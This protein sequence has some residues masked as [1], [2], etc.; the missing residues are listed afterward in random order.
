MLPLVKKLSDHYK[1][2]MQPQ[3]GPPIEAYLRSDWT[4]QADS[5]YASMVEGADAPGALDTLVQV[6]SSQVGMSTSLQS[7]MAT[8]Q[9]WTGSSPIRFSFELLFVAMEDARK[10]VLEPTARLIT[11]CYPPDTRLGLFI[12]PDNKIVLTVGSFLKVPNVL[13][14]TAVPTY[15]KE[16]TPEGIPLGATVQVELSTYRTPVGNEIKSFFG[17]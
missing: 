9:K 6:A 12:P 17:I 15:W 14:N 7:Q 11:L 3:N 5:Q 2:V 8:Y 10:E 4:V 16:M 1:I 13:I